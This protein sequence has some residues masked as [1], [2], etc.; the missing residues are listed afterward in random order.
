MGDDPGASGGESAHDELPVDNNSLQQAPGE[1]ESQ[2]T[3]R[4]RRDD[5]RFYKSLHRLRYS[6]LGLRAPMWV[7]KRLDHAIAYVLAKSDHRWHIKNKDSKDPSWL[8]LHEICCSARR[9]CPDTGPS[10][11]G[12]VSA[13]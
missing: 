10:H 11:G 3:S 12:A 13:Q 4:R 8:A 6:W 1:G 2:D 7:T 9:T 5:P